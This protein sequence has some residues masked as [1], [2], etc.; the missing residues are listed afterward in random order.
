MIGFIAI[1]KRDLD[2]LYT[3][4]SIVSV[5]T[6]YTKGGVTYWFYKYDT[7][8]NMKYEYRLFL[9]QDSIE[10]YT[11]KYFYILLSIDKKV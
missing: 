11:K 1:L 4:N 10:F 9:R 8:K 5:E 3:K 2:E 6:H 7:N